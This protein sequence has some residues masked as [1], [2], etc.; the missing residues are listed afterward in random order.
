LFT[1]FVPFLSVDQVKSAGVTAGSAYRQQVYIG[2][3]NFEPGP[4]YLNWPSTNTTRFFWTSAKGYWT[5]DME[6]IKVL[7]TTSHRDY[8]WVKSS[9]GDVVPKAVTLNHGSPVYIGRQ[10]RIV[11]RL[12]QTRVGK[13]GTRRPNNRMYYWFNDMESSTQENYEVLVC[14]KKENCSSVVPET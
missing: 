5:E 14:N 8:A 6:D 2:L 10:E 11:S 7:T 3:K 1:D 12:S 13:V 4:L 9:Y